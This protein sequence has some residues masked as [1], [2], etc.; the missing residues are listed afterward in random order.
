MRSGLAL[1]A[2]SASRY[3]TLVLI[4][5]IL[6]SGFQILL[7]L[8]AAA[9][10]ESKAFNQLLDLIPDFLR[11]MLG[12]SLIG[13]LSFQGIVC[14]GYFHIAVIGALM[15][16]TIAL[17]T[18]P[19]AEIESR[20]LDLVLSHPLQRHWIITRS[21]ALLVAGAIFVLACM[22]L[23]SFAGLHWFAPQEVRQPTMRV[24]VSLAIN[25]YALLLAWGGVTLAVTTVF[26]RRSVPG[27][28]VG[29][30]ALSGYLLD[31]LARVWRPAKTISW[32]SPFH[33]FNGLD[34]ISGTPPQARDLRILLYIALI[35]FVLAY[36][37]FSRRDV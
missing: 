10:Q 30:T 9:I 33:Y 26:Q 35:G 22:L 20:F 3:R 27:A 29:V 17:A 14:L 8:A 34:L 16:L 5:S 25:L 12:P 11:Q 23:G 4:M 13:L 7:S 21:I 18:E 37:V 28:I 6:L 36:L 32:L 15:A 2:H 1:I 31:Y 19:A 24:A